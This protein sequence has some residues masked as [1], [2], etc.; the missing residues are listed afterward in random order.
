[1]ETIRRAK[2]GCTTIMVTH[3]LAVM[4]MCDRIL[5]MRGGEGAR[6]LRATHGPEPSVCAAGERQRVVRI[7]EEAFVLNY[8]PYN[9]DFG[10]N[11]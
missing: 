9:F 1:M 10:I 8:S 4:Q 2:V 11:V 3:K 7:A 6:H 5:V